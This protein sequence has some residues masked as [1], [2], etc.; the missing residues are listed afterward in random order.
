MDNKCCA[1]LVSV[2]INRLCNCGPHLDSSK[3]QK[4]PRLIGP[5]TLS[6]V[7]RETVQGL[8]DA[9][10]QTKQTFSILRTRQGDGDIV[11]RGKCTHRLLSTIV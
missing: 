3:V 10:L 5:G 4:L 2:Y 11:I 1:L 8:V 6:Q 9:A 7:L